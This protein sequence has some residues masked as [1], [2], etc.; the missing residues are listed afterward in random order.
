VSTLST[1]RRRGFTLIELLVVI[2]IIAVL[3]G[4]L[5]PAVQKVREAASRAKCGNNLH[6]LGVAYHNLHTT[7]GQ[8]PPALGYFPG[9][10]ASSGNGFGVGMFHVLPQ[11]EQENLYR[12]SLG[13]S[14]TPG[15]QVYYPGNNNVYSQPVKTFVCP[16]DPSAP[17]S[18]QVT[19]T[20]GNT[21]GTWGVCSYA[22][23]CLVVAG[24]SGIT[25]TD[26]PV[27]ASG[28]FN[29]QG[30][31]TLTATITDGTSTT[32]LLTEKY[33]Q[34]TN[35]DWP[36]GGNYWAYSALSSPSLPA[37]M[38]APPRPVYPGFE[39]SFFAASAAGA[40][41][42]GEPSK[43]QVQPTPFLGNCDPV[44]ASS[45]HSGGIQ[46]CMGDA[47]VR[48]IAASISPR[49]WWSICTPAGGETL[50]SDW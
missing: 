31:A 17:P 6:Q 24:D 38:G 16:S 19:V 28:H 5:L 23:N 27:A 32:L 39:I 36:Q 35:N 1:R 12:S 4:L 25:Q 7:Y 43:F 45:P 2:A 22:G 10:G 40:T 21:A 49:T 48:F 29:P 41:A 34:C 50:A 46:G 37:P 13:P 11:I 30:A 47:S 20:G 3:I 44:R 15:I 8:L 9:T 14:L 18:G 42:V 26:P 33:A